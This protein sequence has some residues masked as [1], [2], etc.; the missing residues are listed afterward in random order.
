[1]QG[2]R[3]GEKEGVGGRRKG[4]GRGGRKE[5]S[6]IKHKIF[7]NVIYTYRAEEMAAN[8]NNMNLTLR[9]TW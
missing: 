7:G 4:K 2:G 3:E 8:P 5:K 9:T 6:H 1:M